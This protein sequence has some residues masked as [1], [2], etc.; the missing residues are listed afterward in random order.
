MSKLR[1]MLILKQINY[2]KRRMCIWFAIKCFERRIWKPVGCC[3]D[4]LHRCSQR[5]S[6]RNGFKR[7]G[8][9]MEISIPPWVKWGLSHLARVGQ[10][11]G[12]CVLLWEMS[13]W[14]EEVLWEAVL[15]SYSLRHWKTQLWRL[16]KQDIPGNKSFLVLLEIA[17][18]T[19]KRVN[20][21]PERSKV[22]MSEMRLNKIRQNNISRFADNTLRD[23][24]TLAGQH[25]TYSAQH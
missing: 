21:L 16:E 23:K 7:W 20:Y 25:W 14:L 6:F 18:Y 19:P 11:T 17:R 8:P 12:A 13:N 15:D 24:L 2:C 1:I 4:I 9:K 10:D 5:K 22:L 3:Q